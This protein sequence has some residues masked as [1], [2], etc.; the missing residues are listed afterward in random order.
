[1]PR[2]RKTLPLRRNAKFWVSILSVMLCIACVRPPA[3]AADGE[4]PAVKVAMSDDQSIIIERVLYTALRR[5]GYQMVSQLTGMRTAVADVNYGDAA[6]LP[7]QTDGWDITYPN[8]IKVP[9]AIDRVE[10]TAYARSEDPYQYS[11]SGWDALADG[12]RVGYRGQNMYVANK[13]EQMAADELVADGLLVRVNTFEQ[14]WDSL[15]NGETDVVILPRMSHFE[16]RFP[17]GSK[18]AGVIEAQPVY[19]YV[20]NN[21]D[22]L[23]PLLEKAYQ[24]MI[25]DGTMEAIHDSQDSAG[26]KRIVLHINSYNS[27]NEWERGQ[28]EAIRKNLE[29]NAA[30]DYRNIDLNSNELH[31]QASYN[32][33]SRT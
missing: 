16:Y 18:R 28:M 21:Y 17:Q 13:L 32:A 25:A 27:Q 19:T 20:N 7:L 29:A 3:W 14:L 1:M 8:L 31:A 24:E 2:S 33:L 5:S 15:L 10:Y 12:L 23:V 30:I 4:Q 26:D 11:E 6:I 9:V 22:Y